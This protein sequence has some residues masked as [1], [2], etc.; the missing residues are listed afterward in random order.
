MSLSSF[1]VVTNALRLNLVNIHDS[2]HDKKIK[3]HSKSNTNDVTI[4][5]K[6]MM[7]G[8]CEA[9]IKSALEE[10]GVTVKEVSHEK[11]IAIVNGKVSNEK[12]KQAVE[13]AG[14]KVV[15]FI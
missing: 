15:K 11:G 2:S 14:Y 1:C 3:Q 5:I 9:H 4:K 13:N 7:C 12:L 10:T 8:H 6:G